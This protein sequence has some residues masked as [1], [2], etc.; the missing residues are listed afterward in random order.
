MGYETCI[1]KF[2]IED[3]TN[4]ISTYEFRYGLTWSEW[5]ESEYNKDNLSFIF[6]D[7]CNSVTIKKI[8]KVYDDNS[9]VEH[10]E[11]VNGEDYVGFNSYV[12]VRNDV[13]R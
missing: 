7:D 6:S 9:L 8:N 13:C 3:L 2:E 12:L 5:L 1:G 11:Q 10:E 4:N